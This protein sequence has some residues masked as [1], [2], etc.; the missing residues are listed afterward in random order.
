MRTL[1][2]QQMSTNTPAAPN[3][4]ITPSGPLSFAV[5]ARG[6]ERF[7]EVAEAVRALPYGRVRD[8]EDPLAVLDEQKGTCSSKHRFL[9]ALAHECGYTAVTLTL[10]LYAMSEKNTPGV[11]RVLGPAGIDAVP[12]VHCYLTYQGHR[13]DF[14]GLAPGYASPFDS[15]ID[16]RNVSPSELASVKAAFHHD[17]LAQ[18][19]RSRHLDPDRAWELREKCI[20]LLANPA[21]NSLARAGGARRSG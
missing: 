11:A 13:L 1:V 15:L 4:Q 12:E 19:A 2:G 5:R 16:E 10:G 14:T 6:Y 8:T 9:A 18:W 3:F 7:A 17:A 21:L 20:R